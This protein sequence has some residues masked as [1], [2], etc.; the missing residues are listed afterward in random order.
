MLFLKLLSEE[1]WYCR[2]SSNS[3]ALLVWKSIHPYVFGKINMRTRNMYNSCIF[4]CWILR[5]RERPYYQT[6]KLFFLIWQGV[7]VP[8]LEITLI[9]GISFQKKN[10]TNLVLIKFLHQ[11]SNVVLNWKCMF[12]MQWKD[13]LL[14]NLGSKYLTKAVSL[15]K[16]II[17][18]NFCHG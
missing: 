18:G 5:S 6:K 17:L 8:N 4:F 7:N 10:V 15:I 14:K 12:K 9:S 1:F 16:I 11:K 2:K 3:I 13:L